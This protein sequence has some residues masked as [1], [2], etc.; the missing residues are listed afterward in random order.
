M[1]N[2]FLLVAATLLLL[3]NKSK[4]VRLEF[5][6]FI[7]KVEVEPL[8]ISYLNYVMHVAVILSRPKYVDRLDL[9]IT[10]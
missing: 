7:D 5:T 4:R 6:F 2:G 10:Y 9:Y 3:I 1:V 8:L